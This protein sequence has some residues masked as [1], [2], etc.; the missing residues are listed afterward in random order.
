MA[1]EDAESIG[2]ISV[3]IGASH[4][5][6]VAD[7]ARADQLL[8]AWAKQRFT[9]TIGANVAMPAGGAG[10]ARSVAEPIVFGS[11]A[12]GGATGREWE[13]LQKRIDGA[14]GA[15]ARHK[16][17][18]V[19]VQQ[20][21]S[22]P[23]EINIETGSSQND[24][25]QLNASL[26]ET[27]A[28]VEKLG[29]L[30]AV[31]V[32][33]TGGTGGATTAA[34]TGATLNPHDRA[35]AAA[36]GTQTAKATA[37]VGG[38]KRA[39]GRAT[40]GDEDGE[41]EIDPYK[42]E[43]IDKIEKQRRT[44]AGAGLGSIDINRS[45]A[46][47]TRQRN[48]E[49]SRAERRR[50][51]EAAAAQKA[52]AANDRQASAQSL[53]AQ[54][55]QL[56]ADAQANGSD[57]I[58]AQP[59]TQRRR[60]EVEAER[61]AQAQRA[62][63][64][65]G[66]T[67]QQAQTT[68]PQPAPIDAIERERRRLVAE[69][70][71]GRSGTGPA[72]GRGLSE[73]DILRREQERVAASESVAAARGRTGRTF[74]SSTGAQNLFGGPARQ[75]VEAVAR[76]TAAEQNLTRVRAILNN[77]KTIR[78]AKAYRAATEEV[79]IAEN[80]LAKASK[81]VADLGGFG[82]ALRTLGAVSV[83]G[84]AFGAGMQ[85]LG[86]A[87]K[88]VEQ[89]SGSFLDSQLGFGAVAN[90]VTADL[91]KQTEGLR[92]NAAQVLANTE[93]Q[94]GLSAAAAAGIEPQLKLTTQIKAGGGAS[95]QQQ[96]LIRAS[97]GTGGTEVPQGLLGSYG[98]LAGTGQLRQFL[99]GGGG[100]AETLKDTFRSITDQQLGQRV[101]LGAITGLGPRF[102]TVDQINAGRVGPEPKFGPIGLAGSIFDQRPQ[103][104]GTP[105]PSPADLLLAST[106]QSFADASK[107]GAAALGLSSD[108][109]V[110]FAHITDAQAKAIAD[111]NLPQELKDTAS[112]SRQALFDA[113]G[114]LITAY[115]KAI[116]GLETGAVGQG[117]NPPEQVGRANLYAVQQQQRE[118]AASL[119]AIRSQ[120]AFTLPSII[121][122]IG[123]QQQFASG[124]QLPSQ[125]A[126][127]QLANPNVPVGTGIAP[128]DQAKVVGL[129]GQA[130]DL[131]S[132]IN[133]EAEQG[134]QIIEDTYKPAIIQNFGQA[135]AT[136]F[137]SALSAVQTTG[138]AIAKISASISN[139]QAAYQ[140]AQYNFQLMI[141]KRS[142]TDIAGLTNQNLG[143]G[144]SQLGI[145]ERQ[146]L[147]LSREGQQLQ[148]ALSQRQL[149]YQVA[150]A[151]FSAPGVTPEER[152][153]NIAEAKLEASYAQKQLDIQKQMFGNQVQ[154][155]D[156][157]NLRQ[158]SDL[159]KQIFGP[160]GLIA[161][162]AV[163]IDTAAAQQALLRLNQ[164]QAKNVARVGTYITAVDGLVTTAFGYIG[165]LEAAAGKAMVGVATSVLAQFG[166][167]IDGLTGALGGTYSGGG[168]GGV[169]RAAS[170]AVI[171]V[172]GPTRIGDNILAGEAG[173]ET[174]IILSR[175]RGLDSGGMGGNS[176]VININGPVVR[177][178][179]DVDEIAR[180]VMAAL[181]RTASTLG[182]RSVG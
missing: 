132:Q 113:S 51:Q 157:G 20:V 99:G 140:V 42:I 117:I 94:A 69:L 35:L 27:I 136:A 46:A 53:E 70:N 30:P 107:R 28:L 29:S 141:A 155:V 173:D 147:L 123:R 154:I 176:I 21:A 116:K 166:I 91:A 3:S 171:G 12:R 92:G 71:A 74:A 55:S 145:L 41:P 126:L 125:F 57:Y 5:Q 165:Q 156:I 82:T 8:E 152:Q 106:Q 43:Y 139:E 84:A 111:S 175:P 19:A 7:L 118:S 18:V 104:V 95:V 58:G 54:S 93:A 67:T 22:K 162:R 109:V 90:R 83:A 31:R 52:S 10:R 102:P 2:G 36:I 127:G 89:A 133:A 134:R 39:K 103:V 167:F 115:D 121:A 87:L 49:Q 26:R 148:F 174:L 170:G 168:G 75:Q 151:G 146:N 163:T 144:Q 50:Q 131:Q 105:V 164:Q 114:N 142:L 63:A 143:V 6:L 135:A 65:R 72:S 61:Q 137:D 128:Q 112:Q 56:Q 76:Q 179:N 78:D 37:S 122:G 120:Q 172:S 88:A 48:Q 169:K 24:V 85:V 47:L 68:T 129:L 182:L 79:T 161:G 180:K 158:A 150:V 40:A 62:Q 110:H 153:A 160:G 101:G 86:V 130:K 15:V 11:A 80:Q 23:T 81:A 119:D 177:S 96:D 100:F 38:G 178:E 108:A 34:T 181:G 14:T 97:I 45:E 98:G 9:V 73:E 60:A 13:A 77:P 66:R 44:A 149:N 17:V 25:T 59:F 138:A 32:T 16:N 159:F 124:T 1:D 33:T 4:A 64:Q